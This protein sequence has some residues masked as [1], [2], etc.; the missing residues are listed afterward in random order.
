M[1]VEIKLLGSE[2]LNL[3]EDAKSLLRSLGMTEPKQIEQT[4]ETD[5]SRG[6][7]IAVAALILSIPGA[8]LAT[9]DLVDRA[10]ASKYAKHLIQK[11]RNS[12]G[13]ATLHV[14]SDLSIDLKTATEDQILDTI[15]KCSST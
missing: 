2:A 12:N 3:R 13:T 14:G 15:L 10:K 5:T 1:K 4:Q 9:M 8:I 7:P 6:D 11:A